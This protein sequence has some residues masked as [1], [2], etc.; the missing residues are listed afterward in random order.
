MKWQPA[1][2]IPP[3]SSTLAYADAKGFIHLINASA[4]TSSS[5]AASAVNNV[6]VQDQPSPID[7]IIISSWHNGN[8]QHSTLNLSLDWSSRCSSNSSQ[9]HHNIVVSKSDGSLSTL[10]LRS[11]DGLVETLTI[12]NAHSYEAWIAAYNYH[13]P[14]L[15]YSGGDDMLFKGWDTRSSNSSNSPIFSNTAHEAGV[16]SIQSNP[17]SPHILATGSYDEHVRIWDTRY[18]GCG[19]RQGL[20]TEFHVGGGGVWRLKWH[21]TSS[22]R[23]LAACMHDGFRVLDVQGGKERVNGRGEE[24][25]NRRQK[26]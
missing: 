3:Y 12:S 20:L 10:T 5:A 8:P 15:I 19:R 11:T 2:P 18:I 14:T 22:S 17:H 1:T 26:E 25:R 23:L 6:T 7:P 16:T 13:S 24:R 9:D 4:A 21:P